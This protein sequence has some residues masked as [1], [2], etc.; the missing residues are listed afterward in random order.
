MAG[1]EYIKSIDRVGLKVVLKHLGKVSTCQ[2]VIT[3]LRKSKATG[4]KV[5]SDYESQMNK[6]KTI[7]EFQTVYDPR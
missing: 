7:F 2:E 1:C 6:I 3:E 4:P 5:P